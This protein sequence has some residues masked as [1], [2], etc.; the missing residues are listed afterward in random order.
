MAKGMLFVWISPRITPL[1]LKG[2]LRPAPPGR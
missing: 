1:A 2:Q